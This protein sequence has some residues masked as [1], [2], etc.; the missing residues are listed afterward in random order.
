MRSR[1]VYLARCPLPS[2]FSRSVTTGK[3]A[4]PQP[5][6]QQA[7]KQSS[8]HS[9]DTEKTAVYRFMAL[10][11]IAFRL[12]QLENVV[13]GDRLKEVNPSEL[14]KVSFLNYSGQTDLQIQSIFDHLAVTHK[15]VAAAEKRVT[16]SKM[17]A[18]ITEIQ[19]Y[20]DPHFIDVD[21]MSTRAKT[22]IILM[23]KEKLEKTSLALENI[24][25]LAALLNHP[26]FS[27]LSNLRKR[28]NALNLKHMEQKEKSAQLITTSQNLLDTYYNLMFDISK[29]FV[30]WNQKINASTG[31]IAQ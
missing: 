15:A 13:L 21:L 14:R 10:D 5:S 8:K 17:L 9:S 4:A 29:L 18:R 26:S 16:I 2:L 28:L 3:D 1:L 24:R 23:E 19:K 6:T 25:T 20:M 11:L 12:S 22:S 30:H 7:T 31:A 27:E